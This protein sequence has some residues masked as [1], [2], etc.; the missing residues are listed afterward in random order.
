[1]PTK[2]QWA[3]IEQ[4]LS[5]PYGGVEL[6][7][8]GYK[9][10]ASIECIAPLKMGVLVYVN[11]CY[12][13]EWL[14]GEAEEA[15]KFHREHKR[16]F[17]SVKE[18]ERAKRELGRRIIKGNSNLRSFYEGVLTGSVTHWLPW[19]TSGKALCRH[20]RKTCTDIEVV[21]IGY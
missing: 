9:V 2:E 17:Y 19:W 20:L 11:G 14:K 7:C 15:R 18:R 13:G 5:R 1:M 3:E 16:F 4:Q 8:D 6:L 21:K 10:T 12:K